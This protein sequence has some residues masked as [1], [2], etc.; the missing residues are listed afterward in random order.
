[1]KASHQRSTDN[2]LVALRALRPPRRLS[3]SEEHRVAERQANYLIRAAGAQLPPYGT[4]LLRT[5]SYVRIVH[6]AKIPVSGSAH[7]TGAAWVIVVNESDTPF[8]QR[9]TILH[10]LHHV[11]SNPFRHL[12]LDEAV[13]ESAADHF[14]ACALMPS[15]MVR[16]CW[17]LGITNRTALAELYE[18]SPAALRHRLCA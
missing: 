7:W 1:M 18:V 6:E 17:R 10:E 11:V 2:P 13:A 9:S 14:A 8:R 3:P 16:R 12:M 5:M 15:R 4:S